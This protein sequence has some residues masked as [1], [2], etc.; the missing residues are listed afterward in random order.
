MMRRRST[1]TLEEH[2]SGNRPPEPDS[3]RRA[4]LESPSNL[5]L[6]ACPSAA[7]PSAER[8]EQKFF[9]R[10][11]RGSLALALLR[12]TCRYDPVHPE[13]QVNSLYF[14]T[15]DLDQHQRSDSGDFAKDKVRIRWYGPQH[16]PHEASSSAASRTA[17]ET[18]ES[19]SDSKGDGEGVSVWLELK[20]RR[21]FASTKQRLELTV[22]AEALACDALGCGIVSPAILTATVAGFGFFP[23]GH[24]RPV[25]A[26]SYGRHRFVEPR[27]GFRV[28][29][30]S[31]I[32]SSLVLPGLGIGERGLELPGAV[33]EIKGS[34]FDLPAVLRPLVEIGSSWTRYSK[35][36]S[37]IDAH[38][39]A[40]GTVSRLWPPG[41]LETEPGI[42]APVQVPLGW[43]LSASSTSYMHLVADHEIE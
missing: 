25:V 39:A 36:S 42:L 16:D 41:T 24:L 9:I 40:R 11:D 10:P 2:P 14:D 22:L 29:M 20:S 6:R 38:A 7:V 17:N 21:G 31:R 12:R 4:G 5:H 1:K 28:S 27:S 30:D 26:I 15:L 3:G 32:R 35:Y 33:V 19:I 23:P 37:S 8:V 13:D 43:E 18:I 34:L